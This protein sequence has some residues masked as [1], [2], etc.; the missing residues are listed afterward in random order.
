MAGRS[1]T[2]FN[3]QNV[4]RCW[5]NHCI[6][7]SIDVVAVVVVDGDQVAGAAVVVCV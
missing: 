4:Q 3:V 1:G 2:R 5:R 7:I 6:A